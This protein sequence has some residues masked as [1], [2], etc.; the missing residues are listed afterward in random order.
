[1]NCASR[2]VAK[3]VLNAR[4]RSE[5]DPS[6]TSKLRRAV[7]LNYMHETSRYAIISRR[8]ADKARISPLS[9]LAPLP[10]LSLSLHLSFSRR[11]RAPYRSYS[12]PPL[13]ANPVIFQHNFRV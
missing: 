2:D 1:M 7:K 3:V 8:R 12:I 13:A 9:L 10:L 5:L 11:T 6:E 4:A